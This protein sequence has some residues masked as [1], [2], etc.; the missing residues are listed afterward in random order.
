MNS[1]HSKFYAPMFKFHEVFIVIE[2]R[3]SLIKALLKYIDGNIRYTGVVVCIRNT[4]I[5]SGI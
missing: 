4:P 5:G 2:L 3:K 1:G